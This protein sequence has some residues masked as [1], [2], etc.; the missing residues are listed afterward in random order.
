M[1]IASEIERLQWAKSNIKTSIEGKWVEVPSNAKLS[2]YSG[3]IDQIPTWWA[4]SYHWVKLYNNRV[5]NN[6]CTPTTTNVISWEEDW[7]QYWLCATTTEPSSHNYYYYGVYTFRKVWDWDISY[8]FTENGTYQNSSYTYT[9]RHWEVYKSW[10]SV[11]VFTFTDWARSWQSSSNRRSYCY[12]FDWDISTWSLS[13]TYLWQWAYQD[14]NYANY[15]WDVTWY[16]QVTWSTRIA[17][18]VWNEIDD[19][20]YI[21]LVLN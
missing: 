13:S 18:A 16:T 2:D 4:S 6:D 12:Q 11:R 3:Y 10:N 21:Y 1:T 19:D 7:K 9:T 14:Y 5:T 20:W 8:A 15:W 17:S